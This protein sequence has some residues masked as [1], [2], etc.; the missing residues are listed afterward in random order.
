MVGIVDSGAEIMIINSELFKKVRKRDFQKQDR[1][2]LRLQ[3]AAI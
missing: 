2:R 3:P 1:T